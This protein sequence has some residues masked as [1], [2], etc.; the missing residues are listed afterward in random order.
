MESLE[1]LEAQIEETYR[2]TDKSLQYIL[3]KL[4]EVNNLLGSLTLN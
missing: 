1:K 4:E 3:D 2:K